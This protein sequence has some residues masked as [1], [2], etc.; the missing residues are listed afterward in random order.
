MKPSRADGVSFIFLALLVCSGLFECSAFIT[1]TDEQGI[2]DGQ[3]IFEEDEMTGLVNLVRHG[4]RLPNKYYFEYTDFEWVGVREDEV[5]QS[6]SGELSDIGREQMYLLGL[7]LRYLY[8]D[9]LKDLQPDQIQTSTACKMRS[10]QSSE[11]LQEGLLFF[12]RSFKI[13]NDN[14]T[15]VA[16]FEKK[17]IPVTFGFDR[18]AVLEYAEPFLSVPHY[19]EPPE[20]LQAEEEFDWKYN[21]DD[22]CDVWVEIRTKVKR[23]NDDD[24]NEFVDQY[25]RPYWDDFMD[26]I[27]EKRIKPL[28]G[29][30]VQIEEFFELMKVLDCVNA[31]SLNGM[32]MDEKFAEMFSMDDYNR[33]R[34]FQYY[35]L[36]NK[37][38]LTKSQVTVLLQDITT[39]LKLFS[40]KTSKKRVYNYVGHDSSLMP[41]LMLLAGEDFMYNHPHPVTM[42]S[43]NIRIELWSGKNKEE[44][45]KMYFDDVIVPVFLCEDQLKCTLKEFLSIVEDVQVPELQEFCMGST[46]SSFWEMSAEYRDSCDFEG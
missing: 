40:H 25:W 42:F 12:P 18:E 4:V 45:I 14:A 21:T 17:G 41:V 9:Y 23:G 27:I 11:I 1:N 44:Y 46:L 30:N 2:L 3:T 34:L 16:I 13:D 37:S 35:N 33:M 7:Y 43:S 38:V 28:P 15:T 26:L 19:Y 20:V 8:P 29:K 39:R 36:L 22:L 32:T 24:S 10:L 31:Y 5:L 6:T